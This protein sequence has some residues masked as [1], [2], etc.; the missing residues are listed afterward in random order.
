M[1]ATSLS[2]C[3]GPS[4]LESPDP[5]QGGKE[6][7]PLVE[8]LIKNA[9]DVVPGFSADSVFSIL[10]PIDYNANHI[11]SPTPTCSDGEDDGSQMTP[12][13]KEMRETFSFSSDSEDSN[14]EN[15]R[16]TFSRTSFVSAT[17]KTEGCE[18]SGNTLT[19]E[20][21][22]D[23]QEKALSVT[24]IEDRKPD[25]P[26][27]RLLYLNDA[28]KMNR[29]IFYCFFSG[30]EDGSYTIRKLPNTEQ[31]RYLSTIQERNSVM[32]GM[33]SRTGFVL[34]NSFVSANECL[35]PNIKFLHHS[36]DDRYSD[37]KGD[38]KLEPIARKESREEATQ[39]TD[40]GLPQI[41]DS[42]IRF[43][44]FKSNAMLIDKVRS[45]ALHYLIVSIPTLTQLDSCLFIYEVSR[46]PTILYT[47]LCE[48]FPFLE[49]QRSIRRSSHA[50]ELSHFRRE[51]PRFVKNHIEISSSE[52][53]TVARDL[54]VLKTNR[55]ESRGIITE[56]FP[57]YCLEPKPN[58]K[59][60]S[61]KSP[62]GSD[63]QRSLSQ[64]G[65]EI[66]KTNVTSTQ[67]DLQ[68]ASSVK[69]GRRMERGLE[70]CIGMD[71]LE[72]NWSVRQLKTLF[73]DTRAP[74]ID[75]DYNLS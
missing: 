10:N 74:Y 26:R 6:I 20:T 63:L 52:G 75:T 2:V 32:S 49:S 1:T 24:K 11:C 50:Q 71:P 68:R 65:G 36:Q 27:E 8:F 35:C 73:Q 58:N 69:S 39:T 29:V 13:I 22:K 46:K 67:R 25:T 45:L 7:P 21:V 62:R 53:S 3:L 19:K 57:S 43:P 60:D 42:K 64:R 51:S 12:I 18:E 41:G 34:D 17:L 56:K 48:Y 55:N 38:D 15:A 40:C 31:V 5:M 47:H 70:G 23:Q 28:L 9:A 4:F 66:K 44:A 37:K 30:F 14:D 54:H 59:D 72:I 61:K 33:Q 16:A